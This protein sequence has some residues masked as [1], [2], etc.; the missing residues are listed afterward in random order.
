M[1]KNMKFPPI[2]EFRIFCFQGLIEEKLEEERV[3]EARNAVRTANRQHRGPQRQNHQSHSPSPGPYHSS[4]APSPGYVNMQPA[5]MEEWDENGGAEPC[6]PMAGV[7]H[8]GHGASNGHSV[9]DSG[10]HANAKGKVDISYISYYHSQ[11]LITFGILKI[12]IT[13][14]FIS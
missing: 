4:H 7:E 5:G 11:F 12:L 14:P 6:L 3:F 13:S 9:A 10:D 2:P 8:N 1:N